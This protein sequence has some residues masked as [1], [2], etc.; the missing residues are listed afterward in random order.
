MDTSSTQTAGQPAA[1][2]PADLSGI[3]LQTAEGKPV[4]LRD[5]AGQDGIVIGFMHGTYCPQCVQQLQR[6]NR[7]AEALHHHRVSL[8]WVLADQ[9]VNIATYQLAA[10]PAPRF[11]MLP[12]STPSVKQHLGF[13]GPGE[14][15]EQPSVLYLDPEGKVRY[16][17]TPE[18]PHAP[19][20]IERLIAVIDE[21]RTSRSDR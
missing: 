1:D 3:T 17:E 15:R 11:A 13:D 21:T 5:L 2:S 8:A 12:D 4:R 19:P 18:N 6:A 9:P 7:F 16:V 10:V 20:N 14:H